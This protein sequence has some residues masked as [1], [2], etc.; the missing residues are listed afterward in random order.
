MN[1]RKA[2]LPWG[3][4]GE[5]IPDFARIVAIAD[6]DDGALLDTLL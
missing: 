2:L 5:D 1:R 3:K 4:K 6:A